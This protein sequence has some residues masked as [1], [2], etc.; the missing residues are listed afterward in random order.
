VFVVQI[1]R[2]EGAGDGVA[3][4]LLIELGIV[5]AFGPAGHA[6]ERG[7]FALEGPGD[8]GDVVTEGCAGGGFAVGA[9]GEG[10]VLPAAD[11]LHVMDAVEGAFDVAEHHGGAGEHAQR[12]CGVHDGEP[13]F[14]VA[15]AEADFFSDGIGE[16]LAAAAGEGVEAGVFEAEE[17][18]AD[19][20]EEGTAGGIEEVDELDHLGW[21]EGVNV[22]AG[23]LGFDGLEEVGV[24]GEWE[25]GVH[26]ALHEDLGAA[27][28]G[29]LG[30]FLMDGFGG[31]GVCVVVV[32]ITAEG[33]EGAFG[34]A[35]VGVVDVAVD[36]VGADGVAVDGAAASVGPSAE[37]AEGHLVEDLEGLGGGE[38][39]VAEGDGVEEA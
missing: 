12:V 33:A 5:V 1:T 29:E 27:D 11:E 31:E 20:F 4:E 21:R 13:A 15:F 22:D 7:V 6:A 28:G 16:D 19:F 3:R 9:G 14:G 37:I 24:P 35:D 38:A 30:D 10:F 32:G 18:P 34:V 36:D 25:G 2:D 8:E 26:A 39:G 23:E 17:D